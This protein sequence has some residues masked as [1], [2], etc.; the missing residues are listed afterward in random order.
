MNR[1]KGNGKPFPGY[2]SREDSPLL[3][4][5]LGKP[6]NTAAATAQLKPFFCDIFTIARTSRPDRGEGNKVLSVHTKC[7]SRM[8]RSMPALT[9]PSRASA[10]CKADS[11]HTMSWPMVRH[12]LALAWLRKPQCLPYPTHLP[13]REAGKLSDI[14]LPTCTPQILPGYLL[15][16]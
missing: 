3:F 8:G 10:R 4:S 15:V 14:L 12:L 5:D 11:L 1:P 13:T 6:S 9:C 2:A 7:C 16:A